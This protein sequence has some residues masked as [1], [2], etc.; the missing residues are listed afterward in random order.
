LRGRGLREARVLNSRRWEEEF[1]ERPPPP[2]SG[3]E[4]KELMV[5]GQNEKSRVYKRNRKLKD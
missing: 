5:N 4:Q 2:G 3:R 1:F